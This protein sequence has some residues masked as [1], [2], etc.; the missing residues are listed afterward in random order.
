M[1]MF[2]LANGRVTGQQVFWNGSG[3]GKYCYFR[4]IWGICGTV[5]FGG[6]VQSFTT[7]AQRACE[8]GVPPDAKRLN[9]EARR[10]VDAPGSLSRSSEEYLFSS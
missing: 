2:I 1:A 10:F 9:D 6:T 8:D 7:I 4:S 5:T 3:T